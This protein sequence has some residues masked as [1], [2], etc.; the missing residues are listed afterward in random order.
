VIVCTHNPRPEYLSL[1]LDSLRAQTL[2][3]GKGWEC[4]LID[5]ASAER[6]AEHVDLHWHPNSRIVRE[7]RLG[8]TQARLRGFRETQADI[9]V[10]VDDDNVLDSEYLMLVLAAFRNDPALGAVGGKS[11]PRYEIKPPD[12]IHVFE[13]SL[14]CRDLGESPLYAEWEVGNPA[15]RI[16]P[17]CAPVGAGMAVRR[18]VMAAYARNVASDPNRARLDRAGSSLA[19]SGDNDIV[20]SALADGWRV[21]YLPK[22]TLQHLIPAKRLT[23]SYLAQLAYQSSRTWLP[24]LNF[25][26]IRPWSAIPSWSVPL[27]KAKAYLSYRAWS[28]DVNYIRWRGACG[29]FEG[30]VLIGSKIQKHAS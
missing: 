25:H 19:S 12:W 24:A 5:N 9:I 3:Y 29:H 17:D 30:R 4:L 28:G 1:T 27:R 21:A 11:I 13:M 22:L 26:G 15:D 23:R 2:P 6:L 20:M 10:Y 16:Y 14:A 8:L 18:E 7:N